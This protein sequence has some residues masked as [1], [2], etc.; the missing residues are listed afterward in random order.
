MAE[1]KRRRGGC[2]SGC[3]GVLG[4]GD[5]SRCAT[6]RARRR[7]KGLE[8]RKE[9]FALHLC[10]WCWEPALEGKLHCEGCYLK[11]TAA[12]RDLRGHVSADQLLAIFRAQRGRCVYTGRE[13][14]LGVDTSIDHRLPLSRGGASTPD[15]LQWL[16]APVNAMKAD[17][18]EQEFFELLDEIQA[19][20]RWN[21]ATGAA[22]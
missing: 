1:V 6:C 16:Y 21:A 5:I 12:T 8:R 14:T 7:E 20:R 9:R 15:N 11:L 13:L 19:H 22:T 4:E 18:T 2:C 10:I 17:L 3:G